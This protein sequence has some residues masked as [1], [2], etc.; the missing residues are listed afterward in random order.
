MYRICVFILLF[1]SVSSYGEVILTIDPHT[2]NAIK[3]HLELDRLKY[4][5]VA[6]DGDHFESTINDPNRLKTYLDEYH[7]SLGRTIGLVNSWKNRVA[8]DPARPGYM[9][10][11]KFKAIPLRD[12]GESDDFRKRWPNL[13]VAYHDRHSAYPAFIPSYS[14]PDREGEHYPTDVDAASDMAVGVLKERFDDWNR[15]GTYEIVNE[16]HHTVWGMQVFADLHAAICRKAKQAGLKTDVGGPCLSIGYF[17]KKGY[18]GLNNITQFIDN[19]H[20]QLD[21]YS[22]HIYDYLKWDETAQDFGGEVTAGLPLEGVLDAVQNYTVNKYQKEVPIVVSEHGGY[23]YRDGGNFISKDL[24]VQ[25]IGPGEGFEYE[26]KR[27]SVHCFLMT[28]GVIANTMTFM[29]HPHI[30]RKSAPFILL[31]STSWSPNYYASLLVPEG[32]KKGNAWRETELINF[33]KLFAEVKGRRVLSLCEDPDIQYHS[34]VNGKNL[35]VAMNMA[36]L[37]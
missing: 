37:S 34:F 20:G 6:H 30:M 31:E 3:G 16:P 29:Q 11:A 26:M 5:N 9:D 25:L 13:D 4:F 2:N 23:L 32:F 14:A 12:F 33:F 22:F 24:A 8:E 36:P 18:Q 35:F 10:I 19:T 7:M 17:Y 15:P 28:S 1:I 21:F 27:R